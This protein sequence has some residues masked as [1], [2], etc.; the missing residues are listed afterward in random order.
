[1]CFN[2]ESF[3]PLCAVIS[4]PPA[5]SFYLDSLGLDLKAGSSDGK[6][7]SGKLF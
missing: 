6:P 5:F 3:A 2:G 4:V 7:W 1:M